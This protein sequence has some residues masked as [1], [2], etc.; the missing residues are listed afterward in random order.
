MAAHHRIAVIDGR[1]YAGAQAGQASQ[2]AGEA[3]ARRARR[4]AMGAPDTRAVALR[5]RSEGA[6]SRDVPS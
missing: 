6:M 3:K 2:R 5:K 4:R 1:A